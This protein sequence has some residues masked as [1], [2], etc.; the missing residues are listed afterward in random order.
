MPLA[1]NANGLAKKVKY[2]LAREKK[3]DASL[4]RLLNELPSVSPAY[5]FGG[6]I[7][8]IALF[9]NRYAFES[10]IDIVCDCQERQLVA[11]LEG[12]YTKEAL[13]RNRFG[14][15]RIKTKLWSVDIWPAR[16]TWA[17]RQ[18][19][20]PY[21]G[22]RSLLDTTI[23]N[24][25]S[26]LFP[27]HGGPL[28]CREG[29]FEDVLRGYLDIVLFE[30]P[31]PMGMYVRVLRSYADKGASEFSHRAVKVLRRAVSEHSFEEFAS[32]EKAHYRNFYIS[33]SIYRRIEELSD[34]GIV[35]PVNLDRVNRT[36][37]LFPF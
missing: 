30:N 23:T 21:K 2:F 1:G 3:R 31:N 36:L 16:Y 35:G 4:L 33:S 10:D 32:Y 7:R 15:F 17:F 11:F 28:I 8:D 18:G 6:A 9:G 26:I 14:G 24:W 13:K 34:P 37:P 5:L 12:F 22:I 29:Y 20:L 19:I 25:E 27:L